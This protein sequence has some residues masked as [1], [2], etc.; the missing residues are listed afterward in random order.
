[1]LNY[2]IKLKG[3]IEFGDLNERSFKSYGMSKQAS[4]SWPS[5]KF[6]WP[7]DLIL[8]GEFLVQMNC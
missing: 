5:D 2:S 1:M 4:F 7:L 8:G 6:L 3:R